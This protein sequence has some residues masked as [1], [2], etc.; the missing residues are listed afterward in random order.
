ML[1]TL[2]VLLPVVMQMWSSTL[3]VII[4]LLFICCWPHW[5]CSDT[6]WPTVIGDCDL[7][8]V[9]SYW[10]FWCGG[11]PAWYCLIVGEVWYLIRWFCSICLRYLFAMVLR[12]SVCCR[13]WFT[14]VIVLNYLVE[15]ATIPVLVMITVHRFIPP[16]FCC[17]CY[18]A[19][20]LQCSVPGNCGPLRLDVRVAGAG[21]ARCH[22]GADSLCDDI[23][24]VLCGRLVL[25]LAA[26]FCSMFVIS[27]CPCW[28]TLIFTG[29]IVHSW[30]LFPD[31]RW[32][33]WLRS[34]VIS[35]FWC[36]PFVDGIHVAW[37][38]LPVAV[39]YHIPADRIHLPAFI[40]I[41]GGPYYGDYWPV[42]FARLPSC[43]R[44]L[45][46]VPTTAM[47]CWYITYSGWNCCLFGPVYN[48]PFCSRWGW[49]DAPVFPD[50]RCIQFP[51]YWCILLHWMIS[52]SRCSPIRC[53]FCL[54]CDGA[55]CITT[56]ADFIHHWRLL[57]RFVTLFYVAI[58]TLP[59]IP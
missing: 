13:A 59:S 6:L 19:T 11:V 37:P 21:G 56:I 55:L 53:L 18:Y 14:V 52:T 35:F 16:L 47:R 32:T 17:C 42:N 54:L 51:L 20:F 30:L 25:W 33:I 45:F 41:R 8:S 36:L 2:P 40:R 12:C 27:P 31:A 24:T 26:E 58:H 15:R 10:L 22:C 7:F 43:Y 46:F 23:L 28:T 29:R 9:P 39:F 44:W 5:N 50:F 1:V 3:M 49:A 57:C 34:W 48:S 38:S 4:L